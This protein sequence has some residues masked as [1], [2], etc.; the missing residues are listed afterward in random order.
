M[1]YSNARFGRWGVF[2]L[3]CIIAM[4]FGLRTTNQDSM[5][6]GQT[7]GPE[8]S[9]FAVRRT[10]AAVQDPAQPKRVGTVPEVLPD[11]SRHSSVDRRPCVLPGDVRGRVL[12]L[13]V[14]RDCSNADVAL[15]HDPVPQGN[16]APGRPAK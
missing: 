5:R 2:I 13:A 11:S 1:S 10:G 7:S 3:L 14:Y 8:K 6:A 12:W 9:E 4:G 16:I 15:V